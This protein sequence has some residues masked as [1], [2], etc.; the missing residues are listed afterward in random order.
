MQG[1]RLGG[2]QQPVLH[3]ERLEPPADVLHRPA[4]PRHPLEARVQGAE[5][6]QV[7]EEAGL[8]RGQ[9]KGQAEQDQAEREVL[10][11]TERIGA[12]PGS[13]KLKKRLHNGGESFI[14]WAMELL[15]EILHRRSIR[16]F[17]K[18]PVESAKLE[19]ILEAGR[20]APSAKNRQEWRFLVVQKAETLKLLQA[21]SFG[22]EHVGEAPAVIAA[23]TTNVGY[24][25]PNGQLSYPID[26]TFAASF[27][28]LQA[29]HEGLGTCVVTTFDESDIGSILS[30]PYSMKVVLLLLVGAA[31]EQP[32]PPGRKPLKRLIGYEHW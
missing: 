14:L 22:Q 29:V 27:M 15:P 18:E 25:M 7:V 23:C 12:A 13:V 3:G 8:L 16:R 5:E 32:E 11:P 2:V 1:V 9:G 17:K 30:I 6:A 24:Q 31:D 26:L 28:L 4:L 10:H 19:R 21:A 20:Q